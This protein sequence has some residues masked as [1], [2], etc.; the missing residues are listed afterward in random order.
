M[1]ERPKIYLAGPEVFLA[2][3]KD[4]CARKRELCAALGFEGLVPFDNEAPPAGDRRDLSIYRANVAMIREADCGVF[5]LTP[6]RGPHSDAGT[7]FE[8][9]LLTGFG[10][11]AF[12]YSNEAEALLDRMKRDGQAVFDEASQRWV[13]ELGMAI[14]DFGNADNL[15]I[16]ACL[17]E[18][19][20]PLVR[21]RVPAANLF[22]DLDGFVRCLELARQHFATV[23][24]ARS[25][26]NAG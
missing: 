17:S 11:P 10:K 21:R 14:E 22:T 8:L 3:A 9:G 15:M 2:D 4:I 24:S 20:R 25:E 13:D 1:N 6:F 26:V 16:D 23:G 5:N 7:V 18:Q 19:G 12:G